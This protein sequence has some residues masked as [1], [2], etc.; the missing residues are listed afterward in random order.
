[1]LVALLVG[2]VGVCLCVCGWVGCVEMRREGVRGRRRGLSP[3]MMMM[4]LVSWEGVLI[5]A[6][7]EDHVLL[8]LLVLHKAVPQSVV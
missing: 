1:L 5:P 2:G 3:C 8:L 7:T 4:M 6:H